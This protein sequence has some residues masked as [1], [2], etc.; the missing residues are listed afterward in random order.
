MIKKD[1]ITIGL[2]QLLVEG[3]EPER[4]LNRAEIMINEASK[5]NCDLILLPECM[6]LGWTHP[7]AKI[8]ALTIPGKYSE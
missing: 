7:S 5:K 1:F 4:N 8:E 3:G 2:G 6:D